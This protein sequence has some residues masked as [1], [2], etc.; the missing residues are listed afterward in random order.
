[1]VS[2][3]QS[4]SSASSQKGPLKIGEGLGK[5]SFLQLLVTQM[6]YQDPL[7]PAKDTEFIAQLAQFNAL[8][9]MQNLNDSFQKM[10]KWSQLTQAS[11]LIGKQID[12]VVSAGVDTDKDGKPDT[13][14]ISGVVGEVRYVEGEPRLVV[15]KNEI[16]LSDIT[17]IYA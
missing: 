7:E 5:N 15:G 8:E 4:A 3:V 10:L 14:N 12:G 13:S 16:R 6:K 9:Q 17:R 2:A 1:M 11:S